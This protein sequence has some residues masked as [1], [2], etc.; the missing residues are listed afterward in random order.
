MTLLMR[1]LLSFTIIV[2][3]FSAF[4]QPANDNCGGSILLTVNASCNPTSGSSAGATMSQ[5]GCGVP[6]DDVWYRFVANQQTL[7]VT[8]TG[9]AGYDVAFEVFSGTCGGS[10]ITGGCIDQTGAGGTETTTLNNLFPNVTYWIRVYHTGTGSGS[11]GFQICVHEPIAEPQCDPNSPQPANSMANCDDVPKICNLDGFCGTTRG[12]NPSPGAP[13]T[14]YT[15]DSWPELTQAFCGAIDNNSF[16]KFTASQA[17]V[18]LRIYG[19]CT[20]LNDIQFH[21]FE[22]L[23]PT[24]PGCN[25]GPVNTIVCISPLTLN[26]QPASGTPVPMNGLTPGQTYYIMIDGFSGA[27]CDY[28]IAADYGVQLSVQV[29]PGTKSICLGNSVALTAS[30][31]SGTY[32][33]EVNSDLD[34][35]EGANVVA[36][37]TALGQFTY[38]VNSPNNDPD[39]P[40]TGDTAFVDVSTVP[41]PD[42]GQP[43]S[44]CFGE[45]I[46]LNGTTSQPN[47]SILW[48]TYTPGINPPPTVTFS[49]NFSTENPTVTADEPGIYYFILRETSLLCGQYKD[50]VEVHVIEPTQNVFVQS[51][52]CAGQTDGQ[53]SITNVYADEYSFDNGLTWVTNNTQGGFAPGM[54]TVCSKNYLGCDTCDVVEVPEGPEIGMSITQDTIICR[55]GTAT[56]EAFGQGG[57]SFTYHWGHTSDVAGQQNVSPTAPT[58]YPVFA[59]NEGG[60]ISDPDSIFVDLLPELTLETSVD[61]AVCPGEVAVLSASLSGGIGGPYNFNWS[62]GETTTSPQMNEINVAPGQTT[63]YTI[64]GTDLCETSSVSEDI[65]VTIFPLPEPQFTVLEDS[66]CEPASFQ[67]TNTTDPTLTESLFW[68]ISDGQVFQNVE[69]FSPE[70]LYEGTYDV[71]LTVTSPDGCVNDLFNSG[72]LVAMKKPT[73]LFRYNPNPVKMF[74]TEVGFTNLS[75]GAQ[76]YQWWLQGAIP[77][78]SFQ[79]EVEVSYPD[80]VVANY[81]VELIAITEF[82]CSDTSRQV[83]EVLSEVVLYVPNSFTPNDDEHNNFWVPVIDGVDLSTVKVQV[84]NRWGERVFESSDLNVG[85]DG[86]HKGQV[87]PTGVYSYSIKAEDATSTESYEWTGF[88]VVNR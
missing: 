54:Y 21:C 27:E 82:G 49:P 33:W 42:A 25:N 68:E 72:F 12:Y 16:M 3:G 32:N 6:D 20:Y 74:N 50:T 81:P 1:A 77:N 79:N 41:F 75:V 19:S 85:W 31:G 62:T 47:N 7:A 67:L 10:S 71:R 18:Q 78:S 59:E 73:A 86:R 24:P 4:A 43:D 34:T 87:V 28:K 9:N 23:A 30:G 46:L 26:G 63:T 88:I 52:S 45:D 11:G 65:T 84:F 64:T 61:T 60:C 22:L 55:N 13:M 15:I 37:P 53:I 56:I 58:F 38:I 69:T 44:F 35:L 14:P 8:V 66:I 2:F 70:A 29:S 5:S 36:T 17:N 76:Y 40:N 80:G 39:C 48:Q 51:P 57:N 83:V